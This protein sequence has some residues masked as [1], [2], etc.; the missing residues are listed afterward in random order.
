MSSSLTPMLAMSFLWY[1]GGALHIASEMKENCFK[2]GAWGGF[3]I[4]SS[5]LAFFANSNRIFRLS[6]ILAGMGNMA[7]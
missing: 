6:L 5:L 7:F 3:C 2:G 1:P 4:G